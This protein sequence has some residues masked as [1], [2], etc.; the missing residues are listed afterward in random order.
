MGEVELADA[1]IRVLDLGGRMGLNYF[2]DEKPSL[3]W[4]DTV[5]AIHLSI[6][7]LITDF[8]NMLN[9]LDPYEKT[10]SLVPSYAYS[11]L[12][13]GILLS[14]QLIGYDIESALMEKLE[15]NKNRADH[16][17]ENREKENGKKF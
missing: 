7:K 5:G 16:K 3:S 9:P 11:R 10:A 12:V 2:S 15:Y 17:R 8:A 13:N 6:N 1:L 4:T 14:S